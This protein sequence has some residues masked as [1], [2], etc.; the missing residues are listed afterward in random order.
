MTVQETDEVYRE[1]E[2]EEPAQKIDRAELDPET[3]HDEV[4]LATDKIE[5]GLGIRGVVRATEI[6]EVDLATVKE[7]DLG[8]DIV[9]PKSEL[10]L[11]KITRIDANEVRREED[12]VTDQYLRIDVQ[13]PK[14]IR[15]K[16]CRNFKQNSWTWQRTRK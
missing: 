6:D 1:T 5:V 9:G 11:S 3:G 8:T 12:D 2:T 7:A 15:N 4:V 10:I 13:D 16:I 14:V